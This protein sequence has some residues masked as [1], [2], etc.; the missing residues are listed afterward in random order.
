MLLEAAQN[1][2]QVTHVPQHRPHAKMP[3]VLELYIYGPFAVSRSHVEVL[4]QP[5][6]LQLLHLAS[7]VEF[8]LCKFTA[9]CPNA[10]W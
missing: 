3:D 10:K 7:L 1:E 6:M 8:L 5:Q 9:R 2:P 4:L